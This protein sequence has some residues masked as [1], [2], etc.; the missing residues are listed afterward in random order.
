[1]RIFDKPRLARYAAVSILSLALLLLGL[2]V[3]LP[4]LRWRA[5]MIA[6]HLAGQIPDI[7]LG[8]LI[9]YTLPGPR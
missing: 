1:M 2:V 9:V 8:Q 7:E 5:R 4:G 6:L 3:A